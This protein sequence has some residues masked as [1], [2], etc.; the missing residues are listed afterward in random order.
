MNSGDITIECTCRKYRIRTNEGMIID[1]ESK[2][3]IGEKAIGQLLQEVNEIDSFFSN[4][5]IMNIRQEILIS[6]NNPQ[7]TETHYSN[8]DKFGPME[9]INILLKIEGE[10]T[11]KDY[12]RF[13]FDEYNVKIARYVAFDDIITAIRSRR[14]ERIG[15]SGR[16]HTYRVIDPS[17]IDKNTYMSILK[18]NKVQMSVV[19]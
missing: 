16:C 13:L 11:N 17:S 9:R 15:K 4:F 14:V 7:K 8:Q 2:K 19:Q 18:D 5:R 1:V 3:P 10:F 12:M 6:E